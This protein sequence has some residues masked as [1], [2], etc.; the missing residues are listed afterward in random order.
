MKKSSTYFCH[1]DSIFLKIKHK[2]LSTV[3]VLFLSFNLFSIQV[4][5]Q[6]NDTAQLRQL[7]Q[8]AEY[9]GVDYADAVENGLVINEG[10]YQEML[11]FSSMIVGRVSSQIAPEQKTAI[12][13]Q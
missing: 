6:T 12:Y 2:L 9:I 8:L 5:A 11:E 7:A 4:S 13:N 1:S 3:T 10:E